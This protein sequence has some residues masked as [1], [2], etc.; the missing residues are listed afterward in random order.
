MSDARKFGAEG[1][2]IRAA[3]LSSTERTEAARKAAVS[4]WSAQ[5]PHALVGGP[6]NPLKIGPMEI[7]AYVLADGRRMLSLRGL[8][9]SLGMSTGGGKRGARKIVSLMQGLD[10]KGLDTKH[11]AARA[12]LPIRF[13]TPR[14]DIADGY[15]AT[16]LPDICAVLI[17][18]ARQGLLVGRQK[19]LGEDAARLQ[20]GF[21]TLGIIAMVDKATGY[22]EYIRRQAITEIL[23]KFISEKLRP[24]ARRFPFEFYENIFRLKGWDTSELTPNSPKPLMVA[25]ITDDLVYKRLAPGVRDELKRLTPR[26]EKGYLVNKLHRWLSD[27]IGIPQLREHIKGIIML[28]ESVLLDYPNGDGWPV[29]YAK[30]NKLIPQFGKNYELALNDSPR[31]LPAPQEEKNK[32]PTS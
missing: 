15:E 29:F 27:D 2:K 10:A 20:H 25:K 21:A 18:A 30:A 19:K 6:D 23:Q 16:M 32:T 12:N 1:G 11:L 22:D 31:R 7:A 5:L 28:Q 13:V 3:N 4:R 14:G 24:W 9:S 17:E 8:Q 26:N